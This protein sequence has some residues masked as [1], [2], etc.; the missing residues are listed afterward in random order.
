MGLVIEVR[1]GVKL[2][3]MLDVVIIPLIVRPIQCHYN[4]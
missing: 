2:G 1:A 4:Q 3:V